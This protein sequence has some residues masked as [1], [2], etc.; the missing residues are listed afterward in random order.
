MQN[1]SKRWQISAPLPPQENDV[2]K[3]YHPVLRQILYN[4]G[5]VTNEAAQSYL[6]A[7]APQA[8]IHLICLA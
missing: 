6:D 7:R 3:Q 8:P 2:L 5:F 4:R 1:F